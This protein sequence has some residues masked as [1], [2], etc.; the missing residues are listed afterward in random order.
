[1]AKVLNINGHGL[2]LLGYDAFFCGW[3]IDGASNHRL[4]SRHILLPSRAEAAEILVQHLV[5]VAEQ[6]AGE[7]RVRLMRPETYGP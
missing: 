5:A 3:D 1:V 7:Q 4:D 6:P 2:V